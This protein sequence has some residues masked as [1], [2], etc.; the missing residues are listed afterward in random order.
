MTLKGS[1]AGHLVNVSPMPCLGRDG[2]VHEPCGT[3]EY[4]LTCGEFV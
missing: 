1:H 4:C 3:M 2:K